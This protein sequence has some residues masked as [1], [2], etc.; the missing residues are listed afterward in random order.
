MLGYDIRVTTEGGRRAEVPIANAPRALRDY[1]RPFAFKEVCGRAANVTALRGRSRREFARQLAVFGFDSGLEFRPFLIRQVIAAA[2]AVCPDDDLRGRPM[3]AAE[4][5]QALILAEDI[6]PL[7]D[8]A[9]HDDASRLATFLRIQ[10]AQIHDQVSSAYVFREMTRSLDVLAQCAARGL[11]LD[12]VFE[13][14]YGM[15]YRRLLLGCLA[16]W[17]KVTTEGSE[18]FYL[19]PGQAGDLGAG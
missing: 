17:G 11:D 8:A 1:L 14:Q 3:N 16:F 15:T 4:L 12:I 6:H 7:A 2:A 9:S 10:Q 13:A 5:R 19:P 18:G